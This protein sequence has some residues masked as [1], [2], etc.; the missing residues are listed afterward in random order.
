MTLVAECELVYLCRK[1]NVRR[2]TRCDHQI[3]SLR[4]QSVLVLSAEE[5]VAVAVS[6]YPSAQLWSSP[7]P[8][9]VPRGRLA[10]VCFSERYEQR[11]RALC[12]EQPPFEASSHS[13]DMGEESSR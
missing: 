13:R 6:P 8:R 3:A 7:V 4:Q 1:T 5:A 10:S 2:L 11:G 9:L 12:R